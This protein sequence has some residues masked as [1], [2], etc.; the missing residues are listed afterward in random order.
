MPRK[1]SGS[2]PPR[3]QEP[4]LA[5]GS[6]EELVAWLERNHADS[7]GIWLRIARKDSGQRSVSY[8][9][10][11]EAALCFGWIDGQKRPSDDSWWLQRFTP[12]KPRSV[13]SKVNREKAQALIAAGRMRPAGLEQ[14]ERARADG[15]WQAAYDSQSRAEVPPDLQAALDASPAAAAF[16]RTLNAANRYA[17]L[18]RL[19]SARKPETRARRLRSFVEMLERGETIY[20]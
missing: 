1:T 19:Q 11:L 9:D 13:W 10:A 6:Q 18:Y 7:A 17:I 2:T 20:P 16:F 12:R 5:F 3:D 15:R 14:V 4:T 8:A